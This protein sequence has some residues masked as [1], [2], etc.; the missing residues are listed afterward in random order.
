MLYLKI[1]LLSLIQGLTEF[2]PV[3][4]SAHLVVFSNILKM[5]EHAAIY[6]IIVQLASVL[7]IIIFFRKRIIKTVFTLH[8]DANSRDF[9]YKI[10]LAFLP[11]AVIGFLFYKYV[12]VYLY[13]NLIIAIMLII[14][15]IIFMILDRM[16][17][18]PKYDNV[19]EMTK[20]SA[21]KVGIYQIFAMIPGVSRSGS[22]IVGGLLT[23][24]SRKTA[25]E[26]SFLLAI[27]TILIATL[28]DLYNRCNDFQFVD[29]KLMLFAFV[30]TFLI[31]TLVIKW[32][33]EYVSN[34]D[35][36]IFAY[37]R[38]VLGIIILLSL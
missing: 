34:H 37:Y 7:A 26:F 25:V 32:F 3:S 33:L 18:T 12:K 31:S 38:I 14:G 28:Y 35:F 9:S 30:S 1:F 13:S 19:D 29:I 10:I 16:K 20:L 27:P 15:G 21:F 23:K 8:K 2:L 5:D 17:I 4:S 22:T 11:C 6:Q 36:K 24:L